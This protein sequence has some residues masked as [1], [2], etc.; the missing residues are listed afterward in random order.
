MTRDRLKAL[1]VPD[2][3]IATLQNELAAE[4][5]SLASKM[6]DA[7]RGQMHPDVAHEF[8]VSCNTVTRQDAARIAGV[9]VKTI[10]RALEDREISY[11]KHPNGWVRIDRV[12]LRKWMRKR[13]AFKAMVGGAPV[14]P[15]PSL[16]TPIAASS[17][18][19]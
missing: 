2:A 8:D 19:R 6:L 5:L 7:A 10:D 14:E 4:A 1:G 11:D 12:S 16:S 15:C 18:A 13:G 17:A 9:A 3:N